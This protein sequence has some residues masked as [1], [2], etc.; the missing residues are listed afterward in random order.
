MLQGFS[1]FADFLFW[2]SCCFT[3]YLN[4][5]IVNSSFL[6][7]QKYWAS[8]SQKA[9]QSPVSL[10]SCLSYD[11]ASS[12]TVMKSYLISIPYLRETKRKAKIRWNEH[13]NT[14]K[15]SEPSKQPKITNCL[16]FFSITYIIKTFLLVKKK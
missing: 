15:S 16:N 1:H 8:R 14:T 2:L 12:T 11:A 9:P 5:L 7:V 6:Q 10:V 4:F 13:S 3:D